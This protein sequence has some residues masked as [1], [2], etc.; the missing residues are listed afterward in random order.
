MDYA[1]S[2]ID[3]LWASLAI[4]FLSL[5]LFFICFVC[6]I[7]YD[8][9]TTLHQYTINCKIMNEYKKSNNDPNFILKAC[10]ETDWLEIDTE[11]VT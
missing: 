6:W 4:V 11:E 3:I 5:L 9:A 7:Y 8:A 2:K 10:E 1:M